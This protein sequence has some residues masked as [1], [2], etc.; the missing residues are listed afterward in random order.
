MLQGHARDDYRSLSI[1][2]PDDTPVIENARSALEA[3]ESPEASDPQRGGGSLQR[4][5]Q[6]TSWPHLQLF[7]LLLEYSQSLR[8]CSSIVNQS[9]NVSVSVLV[10]HRDEHL[11]APLLKGNLRG[12]GRRELTDGRQRQGKRRGLSSAA[13]LDEHQPR[14]G[15]QDEKARNML[16]DAFGRSGFHIPIAS[17][18]R[19]V[20]AERISSPMAA[21]R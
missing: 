1:L 18:G 14:K 6:P 7:L 4:P 13:K 8:F 16:V 5:R 19:C 11:S 2:G 15:C 21:P 12:I 17:D 20:V 3:A 9:M 10:R